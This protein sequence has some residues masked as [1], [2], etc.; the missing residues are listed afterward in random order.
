MTD[1][2]R[3]LDG[4][5]IAFDATPGERPVLLVH[6][7]A[8]TAAVTWA[9]S[10]WVR[11]LG[12]VGRAAITPDLRGHGRS[13][14]P[15]RVADY[16]P[17]QLAA[18][19]VAVLDSLELDQVDVIGYSMGSRVV[20]ALAQL[21]PERVRRLVLGGAGPL[22]L[23][24]TWNLDAVN[25]FVLCGDL[26]TDPT[27]VA[28]LGP[29]IAAG[30]DRDALVACVQ[31]VAGCTLDV[32]AGIP[33]LFVGGGADPIVAGIAALAARHGA[34]YLELPGRTHLNALTS[35]EFKQ[36]ALQFLA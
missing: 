14:K 18:D 29:A 1:F 32:P 4:V 17:R 26:P 27:I 3:R 33:Q 15:H 34:E 36:A 11:A 28:V 31:G 7:F 21:A 6:G 10:G 24:A 35:R 19:L 25:R 9:G 23:F 16:A 13:D 30:A 22:E 5:R 8:S 20:A 12:E 2:A